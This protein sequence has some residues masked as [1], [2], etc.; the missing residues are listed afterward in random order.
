[1][2]RGASPGIIPALRGT[3][4]RR[5]GAFETMTIRGSAAL[6]ILVVLAILAGCTG[7]A[8]LRARPLVQP[9]EQV[10]DLVVTDADG[11]EVNLREMIDG[12]VALVD[13]WATWCIPCIQAMPHLQSLYNK[14]RDRGL[15]VVGVMT[16]GNATRIGP[17]WVRKKGVTY[18]I[19]YDDNGDA[20]TASWGQVSGIPLLV[21]IDRDGTVV[22]TFVGTGDLGAIDRRLEQIFSGAEQE[23]ASAGA[24]HAGS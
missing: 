1:M 4:S 9:G 6:P 18:P 14:Y 13:V 5:A 7:G 22:D 17:E 10:G 12:K 2:P 8:G 15:I 20:F 23:T 19:V 24:A 11:R 16:D 21:L 3:A